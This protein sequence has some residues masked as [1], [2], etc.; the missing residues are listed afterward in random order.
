MA[1][2]GSSVLYSR[3]VDA[4]KGPQPMPDEPKS[5]DVQATNKLERF[6]TI[7]D[8]VVAWLGVG[9]VILGGLFAAHQ[10]LDSHADG[11]VRDTMTFFARYN[12]GPVL[13]AR[14]RIS[15]VWL[16]RRALTSQM[17]QPDSYDEEQFTNY[18]VSV[19]KGQPGLEGDVLYVLDFYESLHTC[20]RRGICDDA[21]AL[22]LMR[23]DAF[24]FAVH[25][26]PYFLREQS[27]RKDKGFSSRLID[28]CHMQAEPKAGPIQAFLRQLGY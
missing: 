20:I 7:S 21:V 28:F 1:R 11:K 10:Y 14:R 12:E 8:I 2:A 27:E 24:S 17:I 23:D 16:P 18:V 19:V 22:E 4:G 3:P 15:D 6:K 26:G 5:S 13:A 9:A 25:H